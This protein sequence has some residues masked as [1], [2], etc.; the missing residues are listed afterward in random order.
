MTIELSEIK[1]TIIDRICVLSS[2]LLI[3]P[4]FTGVLRILE[5]GWLNI[6]LLHTLLYLILITATIFRKKISLNIKI[7][8]CSSLFLTLGLVGFYTFSLGGGYVYSVVSI[9]IMALLVKRRINLWVFGGVALIFSLIALGFISGYISPQNSLVTIAKSPMHLISNLFSIFT[10]IIVFVFAFGDVYKKLSLSIIEKDASEYKY[11]M[12]Y[13][14]ANDAITILKGDMFFDCNEKACASFKYTKEEFVGKGV[15]EVSPEFQ[16]DGQPS[17]IKAKK[18]VE[19]CLAGEPQLFEWQHINSSGEPF[20]CEISLHRIELMGE[21]YVQSVLRDITEQKKKDIELKKYKEHLEELVKEKTEELES[22]NQD[23]VSSNEELKITMDHLSETQAQLIQSEKMAS[24]GLL[25]AGI[26]HE[27]N[28]PVNYING[29]I[30]GLK[31]SCE[32]IQKKLFEYKDKADR[33]DFPDTEVP[34]DEKTEQI[35][36]TVHKM[37]N[38]IEEGIKRTTQIINSMKVFSSSSENRFER[39]YIEDEFKTVL[40]M[41]YNSCKGKI[42]IHQ[43]YDKD[44]SIIAIPGK[45]Q[46]IFM[47]LLSNA[48]QAITDKGEIEIKTKWNNQRDRISISIKDN[49]GGMNPDV[50][51]KIFDPFFSTKE[52]GKGTGLGLYLTYSYIEQHQG[53]IKVTSEEGKGTEFIIE[54]PANNK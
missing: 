6:Y 45:L 31:K 52:V 26:A 49:G 32:Y 29:G 37:F 18:L 22:I 16:Y 41:L 54:L 2:I 39:V 34:K 7:I 42:L 53:N 24:I 36:K 11:K 1:E 19:R 40:T 47:N 35:L 17:E 33:I 15:K 5:T 23:L 51:K 20:D 12:L 38:G 44:S 13:D 4:Y 25:S 21:V 43:E 9:A 46:L 48:I 27:I 30:V 50:Q 3:F 10:M 14:K 28:N 8:I